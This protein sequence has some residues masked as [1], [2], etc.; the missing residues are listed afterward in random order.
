MLNKRGFGLSVFVIAGLLCIK[1]G[2][3]FFASHSHRKYL[4]SSFLPRGKKNIGS[5]I[6]KNVSSRRFLI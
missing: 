4:T 6:D 3:P 2:A 1:K 5:D